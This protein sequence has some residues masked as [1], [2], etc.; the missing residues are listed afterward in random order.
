MILPEIG[1]FYTN[2]VGTLVRFY[3]SGCEVVQGGG[4]VMQGFGVVQG[5]SSGGQDDVGVVQWGEE[6]V[7]DSNEFVQGG[8]CV[9]YVG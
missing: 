1:F 7:Q 5:G 2:I 6:M 8:G 9:M 3:I 4:G